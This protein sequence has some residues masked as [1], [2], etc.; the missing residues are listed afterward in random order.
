VVGLLLL[1][2]VGVGYCGSGTKGVSV[3]GSGQGVRASAAP[4]PGTQVVQVTTHP[5]DVR[6][7]S[8]L[9]R[10]TG[11]SAEDGTMTAGLLRERVAEAGGNVL[12]L[13]PAGSGEAW[14]C[15]QKARADANVA[16]PTPVNPITGRFPTPVA[17][18]RT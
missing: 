7:C 17:T 3:S 10:V 13:L 16:N 1:G 14:S 18:P 2:A 11:P 8:F 15:G 6:G 5:G 12:L 9:G 4:D